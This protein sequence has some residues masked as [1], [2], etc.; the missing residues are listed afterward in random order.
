M[1]VGIIPFWSFN[2]QTEALGLTYGRWIKG[3]RN[4]SSNQ[5]IWSDTGIDGWTAST[6]PFTNIYSMDF[7]PE[8]GLIL[9]MQTG[10]NTYMTSTNSVTWT[11]RSMLSGM[12]NRGI[13]WCPS[14]GKWVAN[15]LNSSNIGLIQTSD[16]GVNWTHAL[17]YSAGHLSRA[18]EPGYDG[19][20][21]FVDKTPTASGST[22]SI[23]YTSDG[24]NFFEGGTVDIT[25]NNFQVPITSLQ[26]VEGVGYYGQGFGV[27]SEGSPSFFS[28]SLTAST[29]TEVVRTTGVLRIGSTSRQPKGA[30]AGMFVSAQFTGGFRSDP[31]QYSTDGLNWTTPSFPFSVGGP[32]DV[33]YSEELSL[34]IYANS[35]T[36]I[37]YSSQDGV[38]WTQRNNGFGTEYVSVVFCPGVRT[39]AYK[40]G[41]DK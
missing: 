30:T 12:L 31:I 26:Y 17:T 7:S 23:Y 14:F 20:Y 29:W 41:A 38:I 10:T 9:A 11:S 39:T 37:Y 3:R 25:T 19:T 32:Y 22:V 36:N 27:G 28:T 18:F 8:Q 21:Y 2:E 15:G 24:V 1:G 16:D 13:K 34:F 35:Y 40:G 33:E 6:A 4:I 5:I